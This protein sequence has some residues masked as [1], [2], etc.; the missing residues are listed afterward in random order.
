MPERLQRFQVQL[1]RVA[2]I[3]L[4]DHLELVVLLQ[5]VG[6]FAVAAIVRADGGL[7]V[8][9]VPGLGPEHAQE[10]GR[11]IS[12]GADLG[13]IGLPDQ[14]ALVGPELLEGQHDGLKIEGL[15]H[16]CSAT[17]NE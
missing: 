1:L 14:A 17:E 6:V 7:D 3:G 12:A 15:I 16:A 9:H 13:V 11:V 8:A 5:A 2:R 10:G 4:E